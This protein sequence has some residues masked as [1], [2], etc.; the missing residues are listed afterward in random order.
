MA[1][2]D[3]LLVGGNPTAG[4]SDGVLVAP[5]NPVSPSV[6]FTGADAETAPVKLAVR[7]GPGYER[8]GPTA[9]SLQ[10]A[11]ASKWS[12]AP[13]DNGAPGVWGAWG[14]PLI[15]ANLLKAQ[16]L[17]IWA[18]A[19]VTSDE[20]YASPVND[21][22]VT[23]SLPADAYLLVAIG[24]SL[25]MGS[26]LVTLVGRSAPQPYM[27]FN[28]AGKSLAQP[29]E[30]VPRAGRSLDQQYTI[31]GA[32]GRSLAMLSQI[33]T[34]VGRSAALAYSLR[35]IVGRSSA[36]PYTI[37]PATTVQFAPSFDGQC[38]GYSAV[39]T[40]WAAV[41]NGGIAPGG[42]YNSGAELFAGYSNAQ[43]AAGGSATDWMIGRNHL[44]FDTSSLPDGATIVSA[45]LRLYGHAVYV[46]SGHSS[47]SVVVLLESHT[48]AGSPLTESPDTYTLSNDNCGSTE[49]AARKTHAAWVDN[50]YNDFD[51]NTA[52]KAIINKTGTTRFCLRQACDVDNSPPAV[53]AAH[54]FYFYPSEESGTSK[55]PILEVTYS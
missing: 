6:L 32:V 55:D 54:A 29:Y 50:G 48:P 25:V 5:G 47:S 26:D 35:N 20:S 42:V 19:R 40:T 39:A 4:G 36:L 3:V 34:Q 10:G 8:A 45:R 16:N 22:S 2:S 1:A 13:D 44:H 15:L 18:K 11:N 30:F 14:S 27:V 28:I 12:L 33:I 9:I 21:V 49:L 38:R 52:G 37:L 41:R 46:K 23:L 7:T 17:I 51:L 53:G 31:I 43:A 24:R